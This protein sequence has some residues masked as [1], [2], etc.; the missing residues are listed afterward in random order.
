MGQGLNTKVAQIVADALSVDIDRIKITR[1][2]TDKVPNT[3]AT[4]ASSGSDLNGMAALDAANQ[5]KGR[6]IALIC[7][8]WGVGQEAIR[9]LPNRV[10]IGE[11]LLSFDEL[12]KQAYLARVHLSA[13]GFYKTPKIHWDRDKGKGRPFFYFAYGARGFGSHRQ[14]VDGRICDREDRYL[15]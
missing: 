2:A 6:L 4:A 9:F 13:A 3:S 5:L 15:A 10:Q 1:T 7:E 12:I 14:P 8:K 11:E